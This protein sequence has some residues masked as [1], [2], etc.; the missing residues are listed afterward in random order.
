MGPESR[1]LHPKPQ[2]N[3]PFGS[4]EED[5][6]RVFTIYGCGGHL[7][8]V[9]QS[10][11]TN[12]RSPIPLRC[13]MKFGFDRPSGF[14]EEDLW[15]WWTTTDDGPWL[16]YK[17]TYEPK[18]SGELKKTTYKWVIETKGRKPN[19]SELLWLSWLPATLMMIRSKMNELAWWHHFPIINLWDSFLDLKG[20]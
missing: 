18:G 6:W 7:G 5:F 3:W 1:L 9:T 16:Y 20:S 13:H 2:G 10:P 8:H 17:L 15:K 19:S 11:W 4:G 14:G 12:F